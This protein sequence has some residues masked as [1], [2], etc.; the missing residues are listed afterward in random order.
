M[1]PVSLRQININAATKEILISHPYIRWPLARSIIEYRLQHGSFH[2]IDELLHLAQMD[3][4]LFEKLKP[5]LKTNY[6]AP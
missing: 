1:Q 2:A 4:A 3:A 6:I 5:Y